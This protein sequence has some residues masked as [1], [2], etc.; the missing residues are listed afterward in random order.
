M[1]RDLVGRLSSS[2]G[3][4][5][6]LEG[7][8]DSVADECQRARVPAYVALMQ[9]TRANLMG[10]ERFDGVMRRWEYSARARDGAGR[11]RWK[12]EARRKAS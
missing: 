9:W 11:E 5:N 1:E 2:E 10:I 6:P 4:A 7:G 3:V 8:Y 12:K